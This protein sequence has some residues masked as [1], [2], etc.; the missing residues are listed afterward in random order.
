MMARYLIESDEVNAKSLLGFNYGV[1]L[2]S[3][4]HTKSPLDPV[5]IQYH[6]KEESIPST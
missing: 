5:F 1:I 4:E 3:D 2:M 6:N